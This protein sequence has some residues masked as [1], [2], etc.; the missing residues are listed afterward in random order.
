LF[1]VARIKSGTKQTIDTL[2][3]GETLLIC[4][5]SEMNEKSGFD[6]LQAL[7]SLNLPMNRPATEVNLKPF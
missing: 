6:E 3:C 1:D 7:Y 4:Q 5:I 2:I